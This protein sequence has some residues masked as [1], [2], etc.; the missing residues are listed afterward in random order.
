MDENALGGVFRCSTCDHIVRVKDGTAG[1][2]VTCD[3]RVTY[4]FTEDTPSVSIKLS[5]SD[6]GAVYPESVSYTLYPYS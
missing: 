1:A 2:C 5:Q 4:L 6:E 3:S